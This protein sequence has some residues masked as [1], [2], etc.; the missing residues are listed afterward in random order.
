MAPALRFL[1]ALSALL[2]VFEMVLRTWIV[3]PAYKY[4]DPELGDLN[5]PGA[6]IVWSE[7]GWGM[8]R[9][10]SLGLLGP[11]PSEIAPDRRVLLLGNSLTEALNVSRSSSFGG[12]VEAALDDTEV[13]N[14]AHSGW[15]IA[16]ELALLRRLQPVLEPDVVV[17]QVSRFPPFAS[18]TA[19]LELGKEEWE[20]APARRAQSFR[21]WLK[22]YT[23]PWASRSALITMLLQKLNSLARGQIERLSQKFG[24][25]P[26]K[27]ARAPRGDLDWGRS[28][29]EIRGA[30]RFTLEEMKKETE[31][32]I[33]L[34]IPYL[35]YAPNQ[36]R[37][38]LV[39]LRD[40]AVDVSRELSLEFVDPTQDFC[41]SYLE[42]HHPPHGFHNLVMGDG[43][44]NEVGHRL[45]A[46]ALTRVISKTTL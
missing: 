29:D 13:L 25:A 15:S 23:D 17:A 28:R 2:I 38:Q 18:H 5:R 41:H 34:W 8:R 45:V 10:N 37:P 20:I 24:P 40:M 39:E 11:E 43:H 42:T 4:W 27:Q 7:E 46:E 30:L 35:E 22:Q 12:L 32:L 6:R 44:L 36:C 16:A 21:T 14:G 9:V 3:S 31:R 26:P 33:V 1:A 19:H